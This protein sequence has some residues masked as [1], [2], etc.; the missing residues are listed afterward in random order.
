[1]KKYLSPLLLVGAMTGC[2]SVET[3]DLNHMRLVQALATP[4]D[5]TAVIVVYRG[6]SAVGAAAK[7]DL[8]VNGEC[9]G[10][11]AKGVYFYKRVPAGQTHTLSTQ[12]R[13]TP[14]HV[15]ITVEAN[16]KYFV[17]QYVDGGHNPLKID[18]SNPNFG[19][20][21]LRLVDEAEG[22]ATIE[23]MQVAKSGD[24]KTPRISVSN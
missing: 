5:T 8:W 4:D 23:H 1:M 20:T 2:A 17:E 24:C 15:S 19:A 16:K 18:F 13:V 22:Q 14:Q 7:Y 6:E 21:K 3:V 12:G 11:S 10:K 9:L